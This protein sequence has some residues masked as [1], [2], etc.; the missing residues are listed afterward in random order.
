MD[1]SIVS[2]FF[3]SRCILFSAIDYVDIAGRSSA[4]G[5]QSCTAVAR[6]HLRHQDHLGYY[7][8]Y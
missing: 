3:D 8:E 1:K 7:G 6:L 2:P 4:G 5:L